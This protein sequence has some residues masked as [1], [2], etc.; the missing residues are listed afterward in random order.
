MEGS[1]RIRY[2]K[3]CR[4]K[5]VN[6]FHLEHVHSHKL[7]E[8]QRWQLRRDRKGHI[9]FHSEIISGS[10]MLRTF[11]SAAIHCRFDIFRIAARPR[12]AFRLRYVPVPFW[13]CG[14]AER[15]EASTAFIARTQVRV[16]LTLPSHKPLE[17]ITESRNAGNSRCRNPKRNF[18]P[19]LHNCT[20]M[21]SRVSGSEK[22]S[23]TCVGGFHFVFSCFQ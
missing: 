3:K 10:G 1:V 8:K 6:R 15:S 2:A 12:A 9:L 7:R 14:T 16:I 20:P 18:R 17:L 21:M 11:W 4:F 13:E 22:T 5:R 19:A 23:E